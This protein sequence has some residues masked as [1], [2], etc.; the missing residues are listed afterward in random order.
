MPKDPICNMHV[1]KAEGIE[2]QYQGKMYYFCSQDRRDHF[3][4]EHPERFPRASYELI[5]IGGGPAGL[6]AAVYA[7][8][9]KIDAFIMTE[10][11]GGQ[12]IDSTKVKNYMGFDFVTG[13]ELTQ[14]FKDQL[15]RSNYI[16]H[17]MTAVERV[18]K[19]DE[20]FLI[21]DSE[22]NRYKAKA[23]IVATGMTRRKLGVPGEEK[24][25]RKGIFYAKVQDYS[26]VQGKDVVVV[27]GGNSALQIVEDLHTVASEVHVVSDVP[28]TADAEL[29]DRVSQ[30][31][32]VH[33]HEGYLA[34][35]FKGEETLSAVQV[36]ERGGKETFE[37]AAGGAFIAIGLRPNSHL[38]SELADLNEHEEIM[39]ESDCSTSCPG[40]FAAG[41]VTDAYGKRIIIAAGEGARACLAAKE[42]ILDLRKKA[43]LRKK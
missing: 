38:V 28:L 11:L 27:G 3:F 25:Q 24:F 13:P 43:R 41:D 9:L 36:R 21:T 18:E 26:L 34:T 35:E 22:L 39:I 2:A 7:A 31:R 8:R 32:N 14:K 20:G 42:Y 5:I 19:T 23:L 1:D 10:N 6:T 12:A 30:F 37:I 33:K 17:L 29:A 40:L 15:V 4:S 16:D